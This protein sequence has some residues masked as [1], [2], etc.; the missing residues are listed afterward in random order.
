MQTELTAKHQPRLVVGIGTSAG[1]LN[2]LKHLF[3]I[4]PQES[5]LAFIVVQHLAPDH[6][7]MLAELLLKESPIL[8]CE[9]EDGAEIFA[10]RAYV[11]PPGCHLE[12]V[13]GRLKVLYP[14]DRLGQRVAIDHLLRSLA[15]AYAS[16]AAGVLLTGSGSDGTAGLRALKAAGGLAV[17]QDPETAE[18]SSM[19]A[20]AVD[21]GV[22]DCILPLEAMPQALLDYASHPHEDYDPS[23]DL[24]TD[25]I[26]A[27]GKILETAENFDLAQYKESTVHRR[28]CRRMRLTNQASIPAYISR[29]Q[30]NEQERQ[31]LICDLL[32][33][34]T[35]FFRDQQAFAAFERIALR[36]LLKRAHPGAEIRLWVAGCATGEEAYSL[37]MLI[38]EG[39]EQSGQDLRL[40]VFATDVDEEAI[41]VARKGIYPG[42]NLAGLPEHYL[43][44]YFTLLANGSYKVHAHLRDCISFA[45]HN[46]YAD[47]PFSK[48]DII[49]CRNLLIYLRRPVQER[50]LKSFFFALNPHGY[51]LL[52]SS[53][54][55][56]KQKGYFKQLS[57][58]WRLYER[59]AGSNVRSSSSPLPVGVSS[60]NFR[61]DQ[62][63]RG[64]DKPLTH[65]D[66]AREALLQ[67]IAPAALIGADNRIIYIHGNMNKYMRVP[68]GEPRL[69]FVQMLDPALRSRMRSGLFKARRSEGKV[70]V[71]SPQSFTPDQP[72][73]PQLKITLRR[74][75]QSG[76]EDGAVVALFEECHQEEEERAF[77]SQP[78]GTADQEKL[79]EAIERELL[80]TR[81]ELQ[82]TV[83]ELE[84]STE[85][86]KAAH[87]EALS[88][89]EELQSANEE[90]E[91]STEELR[92]LNEEL[93]TV[94][95]QLKD[96]ID[97]VQ[98]A[99]NDLK[100]FVSSSNQATLFL[101]NQLR[102]KRYTPAAERLLQLGPQD[103]NRPI[104]DISRPL[105]D[106]Q[107]TN[108]LKRVLDSLQPSEQE[109]ETGDGHWFVR[110]IMPYRTEDRRI[111]GVVVTFNDITDLK[112]A[113]HSLRIREHQHAVL[114]KLG[115]EA[116]RTDDITALM[117]Q[118]TRETAY[119]LDAEFCKVLE[120]Q[121]DTGDLLLKAGVGFNKVEPGK[122]R[123]PGDL[124]SQAG[125]TLRERQV[126]IVEDLRQER[127]F[128]GPALLRDHG[129]VSGMSCVIQA[130][131]RPYGVLGVHTCSKRLFTTD[132]ANF[133]T[134]LANLLSVALQRKKAEIS[135]RESE[136][137]FNL[138][139]QA[140]NLGI[141]DYDPINNVCSWDQ[142]IRSM[143]GV[144]SDLDPITNEIFE[145]GL[146][147]DDRDRVIQA[148]QEATQGYNNGDL[149][150]DYRVVNR[151]D[152]TVRWV[153]ATG[154]T[155][156]VN[157][158][159]TRMVGTAQDITARKT[160]ELKLAESEQKLRIAKDSNR[161]GAFE[162]DLHSGEQ[163]WDQILRDTWGIEAG[164]KV[165]ID[166]FYQGLHPDD[167]APTRAAINAAMEG[168]REGHYHTFYRVINKTTKALSWIEASGQVLFSGG[169]P[170]K[171]IGMIIDITERKK[172]EESLHAAVKKL[173]IENTKKNEFIAMLGHELRNPLAAVNSGI[174]IMQLDPNNGRW[175]LD[176]MSNNIKLLCSLLDD[177][178]D[179]TRISLGKISL[180][181]ETTSL[182]RLLQESLES[183]Q[184]KAQEKHQLLHYDIPAE[185]IYVQADATR[186]EQVFANILTNASKFT[187]ERGRIEVSLE[188]EDDSVVI[189]VTDSGIGIPAEKLDSVFDPFEQ[190]SPEKPGNTGLGIGLSLVQ[191]FTNMHGGSV[192]VESE[193]PHRGATFS[194]TLPVQLQVPPP[195]EAPA[196]MQPELK[197]G[198]RVMIVDDNEDAA[199]GLGAMLETYGCHVSTVHT[200]KAA[201]DRVS[202]QQPEVLILDI[203]LPDMSGYELLQ[204]LKRRYAGSATYVAL[205]GYSPSTFRGQLPDV[206]F[207]S[208]LT[209][210]VRFKVLLEI[211]SEV[212]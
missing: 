121:A 84:T 51:L 157:G 109:V 43:Q 107:F 26:A 94:N 206:T 10:N 38:L 4:L 80:E 142:T 141:H 204:Q 86:L 139:R 191:Q 29:L 91:A 3:S 22:A 199:H 127:R 67:C 119:T 78:L 21:A 104:V 13:D 39:T 187:P 34:V 71:R 28:I 57:Q 42:A 168:E 56:G 12:V 138:A 149:K 188:Q 95:A 11:I 30:N 209:K 152:Q 145:S 137:R 65:A 122:T 54:S 85:E 163:V 36:R 115:L 184:T 25:Q 208:Y 75:S 197:P 155:F 135:L 128:S 37:A 167:V 66:K 99:H 77:K 31:Q 118:I 92:S 202:E 16:R 1:G 89:N 151:H 19:P 60:A 48:M 8:V 102:I 180:N 190:V 111:D 160:M 47:P 40:L 162:Y 203:G 185:D 2:A 194:V 200:A 196:P 81:E 73:P 129:V 126:V 147:P 198:L 178:L 74:T 212:I 100:N 93:T 166:D 20:H 205:S 123:V 90:L 186:L 98:L 189:K 108:E 58:K 72:G 27:I 164:A 105:V 193:G 176:M 144:P 59:Q 207:D 17:V 69:D 169:Q 76:L 210:P 41:K 68:E 156:F 64:R 171:M 174:Q 101:N 82:N 130:D 63:R 5:G 7:S 44:K 103:L 211:L 106:E 24:D 15:R 45:T 114:A 192:K 124:D 32:I 175:A 49:S 110:R 83:E 154:K 97:E 165:T 6:N 55:A 79:I 116:M 195:A 87:E 134:S 201:L 14:T 158:Q 173:G 136:E 161:F 112:L 146:H 70:V 143:W 153:E 150:V 18:Y 50:V 117:E 179:L 46:V 35:D 132:D 23:A 140:A 9:A 159:A 53:E 183:F 131:G 113:A 61:L 181:K 96:K 52:G 88:T 170:G 120:Y 62:S 133:L 177:L 182:T 172:L 148:L 33:N 125:Y